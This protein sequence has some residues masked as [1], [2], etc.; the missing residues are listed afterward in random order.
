[1]S[2]PSRLIPV[3]KLIAEFSEEERSTVI[4]GGSF[5]PIHAGH[6]SLTSRLCELFDKVVLAPTQQNPWKPQEPAPLSSRVEMIHMALKA[7]SL[8]AEVY[9]EGYIYV[10]EVVPKFSPPVFW[11]IGE[12]LVDTVTAWRS[13][14]E[15]GLFVVPL[16]FEIDKSSTAI[17]S[18]AASFHP[19][20][21]GYVKANKLYSS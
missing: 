10:D 17:R 3:S 8:E 13:W 19:A 16:P 20:I 6:L 4:F 5:D 1:L 15:M 2:S 18:G 9:E 14:E 11:A 12:D 21:S 7:E